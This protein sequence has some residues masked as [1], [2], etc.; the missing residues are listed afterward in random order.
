ME[1]FTFKTGIITLELSIIEFYLEGEGIWTSK[2][3][4]LISWKPMIK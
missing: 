1:P 2:E 4:L 3:K